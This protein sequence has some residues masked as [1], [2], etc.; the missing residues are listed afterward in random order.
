MGWDRS[1]G[2]WRG[3]YLVAVEAVALN[4]ARLSLAFILR[5]SIK[6]FGG[7]NLVADSKLFEDLKVKY[8]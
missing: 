3:R 2:V 5:L 1:L 7:P 8:D 4:G 6:A